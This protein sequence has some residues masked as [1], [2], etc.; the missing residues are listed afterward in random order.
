ME[1]QDLGSTSS[2]IGEVVRCN[3][4]FDPSIIDPVKDIRF[5]MHRG[6]RPFFP[7][8]PFAIFL[9]EFVT[10]HVISYDEGLCYFPH[11]L[12]G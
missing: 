9:F 5:C 3:P 6:H 12:R 8:L 7:H 10:H 4:G 1:G 11:V 2:E